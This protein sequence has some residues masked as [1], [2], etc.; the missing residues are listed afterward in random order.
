MKKNL[1]YFSFFLAIMLLTSA[2]T[3]KLKVA[4]QE[5]NKS[6]T[7]TSERDLP[8]QNYSFKPEPYSLNSKQ[9]DPELLGPQSTIKKP[10]DNFKKTDTNT[11][12]ALQSPQN[13]TQP[14]TQTPKKVQT[15]T[16]TKERCIKLIGQEAYDKYTK[17]FGSEKAALRKCIILQRIQKH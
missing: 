2:C 5:N 3:P 14:I 7:F 9:K 17:Q 6:R 13:T 11:S 1:G 12:I 8:A 16:M 10:I 15:I 4:K